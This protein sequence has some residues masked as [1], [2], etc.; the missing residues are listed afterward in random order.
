[1]T[2]FVIIKCARESSGEWVMATTE[3]AFREPAAA[4]MWL[5]K[6]QIVWEETINGALCYCERA[7]HETTLE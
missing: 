7:V 5:S 4:K 2:I 1:M 6:Q 3:K